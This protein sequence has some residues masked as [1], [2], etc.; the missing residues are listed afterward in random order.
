MRENAPRHA[1]GVPSE[2]YPVTFR[3]DG[4]AS[5]VTAKRRCRP[6]RQECRWSRISVDRF[7]RFRGRRVRACRRWSVVALECRFSA[8][9]VSSSV[10]RTAASNDLLASESEWSVSPAWALRMA[11]SSAS[12]ASPF[13]TTRRPRNRASVLGNARAAPSCKRS[14]RAVGT[15]NC[16]AIQ[17]A[18][19]AV[20]AKSSSSRMMS[21]WSIC[22][23]AKTAA[24][25]SISAMTLICRPFQPERE[26]QHGACDAC[27][28]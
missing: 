28:R 2:T 6:L 5:G 25:E 26:A 21:G 27:C 19:G 20:S 12:G 9:V 8:P 13:E 24:T 1:T 23:N 16:R 22:A 11:S 14:R 7:R 15:L 3:R 18:S 4:A 10:S 17:N